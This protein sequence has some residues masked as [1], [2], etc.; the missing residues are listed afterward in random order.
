[1]VDILVRAS[2]GKTVN[3]PKEY[4]EQYDI[5]LFLSLCQVS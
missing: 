1:M 4:A 3:L 5:T 2:D